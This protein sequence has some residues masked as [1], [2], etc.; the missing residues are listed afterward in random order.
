MQYSAYKTSWRREPFKSSLDPRGAAP[1]A[2]HR[3]RPM[4]AGRTALRNGV[5]AANDRAL[6]VS[7]RNAQ[8]SPEQWPG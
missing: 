2:L 8:N 7:G 1:I 4:M 6:R 3:A 5:R